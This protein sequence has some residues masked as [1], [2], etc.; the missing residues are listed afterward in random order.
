MTAQLRKKVKTHNIKEPEEQA[1]P[2]IIKKKV[3]G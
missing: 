3:N 1:K 2:T